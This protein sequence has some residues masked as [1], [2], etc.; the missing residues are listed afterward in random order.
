V[1][2][3]ILER[4]YHDGNVKYILERWKNDEEGW[5]SVITSPD[6]QVIRDVRAEREGT[7]PHNDKVIE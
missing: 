2:Y 3:R 4:E 7:K 1:K 6:L 5:V